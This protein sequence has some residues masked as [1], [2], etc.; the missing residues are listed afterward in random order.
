MSIRALLVLSFSSVIFSCGT[1]G[2]QCKTASD[3]PIG[4]SC[5]Q[6]SCR[7]VNTGTGSGTGLGGMGSGSNSGGGTASAGGSNT[8]GGGNNTGGSIGT[9]GGDLAGGGTSTGGAGGGSLVEPDAGTPNLDGGCGL[10]MPGNPSIKR[11]CAP[12]TDNECMGPTDSALATGGVPVGRRNAMNGN[13]FDDDCDGLVDEGCSCPGN[14]LTKECYLVPATQVDATSGLPVGWCASNAKGSLDCVGTEFA[15]WSGVCRG[16]QP[17]VVSDSCSPGDFNCDGLQSNNALE[18]C[19]CAGGGVTCPTAPITVAPYPNP[20]QLQLVDGSSW[21]DQS[22]RTMATN[23]V[24]TVLG[25]DCDNVLPNPTFAIYNNT[26]STLVNTRRGVRTPVTLQT[27]NGVSKYVANASAP[28]IA[29]QDP[30]AGNGIGGGKIYPA[31]GLSGDYIVQG[32]FTLD[33]TRHVCTQKVQVRAPGIRAELCWNTVGSSDIDLH[34]ARLQGITCNNQGWT[35]ASCAGVQDCYYAPGSGCRSQSGNPPNWGYADSANSA[36]LGWASKRLANSSQKCTNPRL[37]Q[38]NVSCNR[39][40]ADPVAG[41]FCGPENTN[42]DNPKNGDAFVVG[43]NHYG[44]SGTHKPHVNLYCNGERVLSVGYNPTGGQTMYPVLNTV[45]A[46][47]TGDFWTV[48]T[49]KA[50]VN[51]ANMLT[52]CDIA[53]IPSR[54][55]DT[56]RDGPRGANMGNAICVDHNYSSKKFVDTGTTQGL[57]P[58]T[59][60][61]LP[62][63]WCKH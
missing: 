42:I 54:L 30:T 38:D 62:T 29:I 43:V 22:K 6:G 58:G 63:N 57:A 51:G 14:G 46:D 16:A 33:G 53:T 28:Y 13:G 56:T 1:G 41:G 12:A 26:N 61:T 7:A 52:S 35:G 50:N 36:C 2:T 9:G 55:S 34:F 21:I 45:G 4:Q 19:M 8:S 10:P 40:E 32:E 49:I 31:F 11:L 25:G 37:D 44:G 47:T 18:G 20:A 39:N 48:A 60:P 27:L 3:C 24:W 15:S 23:W 59:Q 5:I 17:P